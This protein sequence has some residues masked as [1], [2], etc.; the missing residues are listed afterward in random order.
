MF[1]KSKKISNRIILLVL[2]LELTSISMWG[3]A[4]YSNSRSELLDSISNRLYEVALRME[5]ELN[6]FLE[7]A[8]LHIN[9][10]G[11]SIRALNLSATDIV[12]IVNEMFNARPEIDELS[13]LKTDGRELYRHGRMTAYQGQKMRNL[14][15]D[16]LVKEALK[17]GKSVGPVTFSKYFEPL[18]RMVF[19]LPNNRGTPLLI[20]VTLNL[21]WMWSLAQQ[22]VIGE[23]GYVYIVGADGKL[24]SYPDHSLVLAGKR[25]DTKLPHALFDNKDEHKMDIYSNLT[26]KSVVGISHYDPQMKWW[27]VVE[28]PTNEALVPLTR[29]LH[30]FIFIF[31]CAA[32]F[33]IVTVLIFVKITMRPLQNIMEAIARISN[34]ESGVKVDINTGSELSTLADGINIMACKLDERIHMLMESQS[35]L[36]AS[37]MRYQHLNKS[38]EDKIKYATQELRDANTKLTESAAKAEAASESKSMFLANTSHELRTP[39]NAIIGY[40]ELIGTDQQ[41]AGSF[42]D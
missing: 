29:M 19:S 23:T 40:S 3:Y 37:K 42:Q 21:K 38:L 8:S 25:V 10:M 18:I 27:I 11:N 9:A 12:P 5:S 32:I 1:F 14:A 16:P 35:A 41:S 36:M 28:L 20:D 13:I 17:S 31:I 39:L 22:L 30:R 24:I 6:R 15:A 4:T 2:T 26:G 33:T 7:P 34:G